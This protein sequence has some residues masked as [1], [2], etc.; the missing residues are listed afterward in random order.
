MVSRIGLPIVGST[1]LAMTRDRV[2]IF[3]M[4]WVA[5]LVI[6][7]PAVICRWSLISGAAM[8]ERGAQ[9]GGWLLQVGGVCLAL[10]AFGGLA[11]EAANRDYWEER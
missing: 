6:G 3:R 11:Y 8:I 2:A 4:V 10:W 5:I 1:E 7:L 9:W